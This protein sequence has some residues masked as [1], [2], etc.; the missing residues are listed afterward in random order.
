MS[1]VINEESYKEIEKELRKVNYFIDSELKQKVNLSEYYGKEG[2][3][4]VKKFANNIKLID[5][6]SSS[7]ECKYIIDVGC[8][9]LPYLLELKDKYTIIGIDLNIVE[10]LI[11]Y[12]GV[13]YIKC[14]LDF[15]NKINLPAK[16]LQASMILCSNALEKVKNKGCL[17][18]NIKDFMENSKIGLI[19]T[20]DRSISNSDEA[21]WTIDELKKT[22]K[23]YDFNLHFI[24]LSNKNKEELRE[25]ILCI[26]GKNNDNIIDE[27]IKK[28]R[29]VAIM[30]VINEEDIIYDSVSKLKEN[31][32]D[33]YI[34]DNWS[35]DSTFAI[36]QNLY[37]ENKIIGFERFPKEGPTKYYEWMEILKRKEQLSKELDA[38]WFMHT[39]ADEIKKGPWEGLNLKESIY[40]V[41][42]MGF[43]AIDCNI[44]DFCPVDNGFARGDF[45]KYFKYTTIVQKLTRIDTWKKVNVAFDLA[46][47]GGHEIIFYG[48]KIF[49]FKFLLKHYSYRSQAH[50]LKK[51]LM[52]RKARYSPKELAR[53]WHVHN[54]Y[55]NSK[56]NFLM[57]PEECILY[58]EKS[59]MEYFLLARLFRCEVFD[60]R[61]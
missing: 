47:S 41:D 33:V 51:V 10:R 48:R 28:F 39:D 4:D 26:I 25:N 30:S 16:L 23:Y 14:D 32:I 1:L 61:D 52:E 18:S 12:E 11:D 56:T 17:L 2:Y 7:F 50:G 45:E 13:W 21:I 40:L 34:M 20:L 22:L 24:G 46:N 6:I 15:L 59:F 58:V 29:V 36:I 60:D 8:T 38:D 55:M 19:S 3:K 42:K 5:K 27:N 49:P 53:G 37:K 9:N 31:G 43:N 57:N 35:T 54:N 44:I